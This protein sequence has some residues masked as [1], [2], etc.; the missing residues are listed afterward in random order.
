MDRLVVL[1]HGKVIEQGPHQQLLTENGLYASLWA[2]QS[3]GFI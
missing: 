2:R 3:G 1:D